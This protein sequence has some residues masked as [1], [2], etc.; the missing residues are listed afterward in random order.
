M[1]PGR[2]GADPPT[3]GVAA[4]PSVVQSDRYLLASAAEGDLSQALT[5]IDIPLLVWNESGAI[6]LANQAAADLTGRTVEDLVG[7]LVKD[8]ASPTGIVEQA[9]AQMVAG[10]FDAMRSRRSLHDGRG[11]EIPVCATSRSI[12]VDGRRGGVT[13]F[14]PEGEVG[15]LGVDPVR[16]RL[17]LVPVAVGVA[18]S[19]WTITAI[20]IEV[21]DLLDRSPEECVGRRLIDWVHPD[22]RSELSADMSGLSTSA[23]VYPRIRFAIGDGSWREVCVLVGVPRP[24][25][26]PII[27]FALVGVLEDVSSSRV[28]ELEMRLRRIGSEVRAA[29]LIDVM[30]PVVD[31]RD[32]PQMGELTN[33]QWEILHRLLDGERVA[34]IASELYISRSTVRNHLATIFQ[35]FDVHT[36]A[37]L[38]QLL[39]QPKP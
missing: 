25:A 29:G 30:D 10:Q 21:R 6:Q 4:S 14:V 5:Q 20:S 9:I 19:D 18:R 26:D 7:T 12:E 24:D 22:D 13:M 38:I 31:L 28:E 16:R 39:R 8:Y 15:R 17:E 34:T 36:Q 11:E 3:P 27:R 23:V 37:E 1:D 33:R 32:F 2:G 35:K